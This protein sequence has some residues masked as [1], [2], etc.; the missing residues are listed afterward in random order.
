[1]CI[2]NYE[3][4][5]WALVYDQYNQGRHQKE[6]LFYKTELGD[7]AGPVLEIACGTGM[8]LLKL[9]LQGVDI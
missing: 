6:L 9:L 8:I 7:C 2:I 1:M 4:E 5:L 3:D